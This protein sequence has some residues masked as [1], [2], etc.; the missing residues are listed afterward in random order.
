[1]PSP[2]R[3]V[4]SGTPT[5]WENK[6]GRVMTRF[7]IDDWDWNRDRYGAWITFRYKGQLYRFEQ[8]VNR[9]QANGQRKIVE[10]TDCFAQLVLSLED[11]A[12]MVERGIYDLSTWIAGMKA[13]PEA[14][15]VPECLQVLG[16]DQLP[17]SAEDV[18]IRYRQLAKTAHPDQGGNAQW[19][20]R[21]TEAA[22][23]AEDLMKG[24]SHAE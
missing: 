1:M 15:T 22:Q 18:K 9:A 6:L 5:D 19:F 3:R 12:R 2:P 17:A 24:A 16:F 7:G 10:G 11:L 23:A 14:R 13:L 8:T 21:I 20:Q 4:Y